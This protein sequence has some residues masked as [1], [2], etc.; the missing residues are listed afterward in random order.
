MA[1]TYKISHRDVETIVKLR[2][3]FKFSWQTIENKMGY[4]I[5]TCRF[6]YFLYKDNNGNVFYFSE[7]LEK[8]KKSNMNNITLK[9][10]YEICKKMG[11]QGSY[12]AF[13]DREDIKNLPLKG[14]TTLR[15][16]RISIIQ[17]RLKL[18]PNQSLRDL[19][20]EVF[21]DYTYHGKY[22]MLKLLS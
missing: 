21:Y 9:Q 17:Q 22:R 20:W 19:V 4:N 11:Y 5:E 3:E 2:D 8:I 15:N 1:N 13:R 18:N 14:S 12:N 7:F 16:K 10:A 6:H